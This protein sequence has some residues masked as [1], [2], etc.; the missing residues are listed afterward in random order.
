MFEPNHGYMWCY[1]TVREV[2]FAVVVLR[3]RSFW[4][5]VDD[6]S[7]YM[8]NN[9]YIST[10]KFMCEKNTILSA[11]AALE[12]RNIFLLLAPGVL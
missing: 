8:V 2:Y 5:F 11:R 1:N 10:D 9:G 7:L 3:T 6:C 12:M 4:L